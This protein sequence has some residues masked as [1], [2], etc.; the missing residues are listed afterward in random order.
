MKQAV[1]RYTGGYLRIR[2]VG[3]SP[4]R[5]LNLC[6]AN[7]IVIWDLRYQD[8]GYQFLVTVKDY[9]RVRPLVKKA[10]VHLRIMGRYGLPFFLHQNRRRKLYAAGVAAFFLILFIMSRFIWNITLDGNYHFTD[11]TLLHYLDSLDI[12]YGTVKSGIDCDALEESIRSQYPE[13]IWV[14]ARISGTRLMIKVKENEVMG[15]IP[16][17]EDTPQDLVADKS[18]VITR[19]VVRRGKAQVAVGDAVEAGQVLVSG[20]IPI[21]NDAEELVNCQYVHAD[22]DIYAQTEAGY[23]EK[24]SHFVTERSYNGKVRHG[25]RLRFPGLSFLWM[26]PSGKETLWEMTGRYEQVTVC[27]DFYLPIWIDQITARQYENYERTRTQ[28]ELETIKNQINDSKIQNLLEKGVQIIENDVKI[29]DKS[30]GWEIQGSFI[31]E[32]K[33]GTGQDIP[34]NMNEEEEQTT[35]Q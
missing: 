20:T 31:L 11:D 15:T 4:E 29:L 16:V 26:L 34:Q 8:N 6:M 21:Y 13:I 10:Q 12:R 30:S 17:R 27:G 2:L 1:M 18:G 32:E 5:F 3:F 28:S 19:M 14:S 33:V 35:D 23:T 25:L 7:Q 24:L 9:R 22:A